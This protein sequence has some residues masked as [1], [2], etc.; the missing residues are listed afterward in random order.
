MHKKILI[1]GGVGSGK[2]TLAKKIA[3]YTGYPLVHLDELLLD[4]NWKAVD[5]SLWQD[6]SKEFLSKE[7]GVIDGNYSNSLPAR[8]DWA[9]LIIFIDISTVR[10]LSRVFGRYIKNKIGL[11]KRIGHPKNSKNKLELEL[12]TWT[13]NWNRKSKKKTLNLLK[14]TYDKKIVFVT[15]PKKL[16]LKKILSK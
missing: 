11:E 7:F 1:L 5:K 10:Q 12:I 3:D 9:D 8:I 15:Q 2:S 16:K 6:M 13:Y 4:A 14:R